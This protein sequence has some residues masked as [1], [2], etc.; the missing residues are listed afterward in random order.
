MT[1]IPEIQSTRKYD[2]FHLFNENRAV[3]PAHIERLQNDPTFAAKFCTSPI[4]VT[5]DFYIIDGQHRYYAAR[6]LNIPIFYIVDEDGTEQDI[7]S[8]NMNMVPWKGVEYVNFYAEKNDSYAFLKSMIEKHKM[9]LTFFGS[10]IKKIAGFKTIKYT[11]DL[12]KGSLNFGKHMNAIKE[13]VD[14]VIPYLKNCRSVKG[15]KATR[16]IFT[17]SYVNSYAHFFLHDRKTLEKALKNMA[18]AD[19][20]FPYTTT[21]EIARG[22]VE[23]IAKWRPA[24]SKKDI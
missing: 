17:D 21:Y 22:Y 15:D 4:I 10:V 24:N 23:K 5:K 14:L 1:S 16:P 3:S 11:Y 18:I 7:R 6:N 9:P 19:F 8:R 13:C 12:K 2:K 20:D